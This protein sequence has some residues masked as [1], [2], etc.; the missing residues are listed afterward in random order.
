MSGIHATGSSS[1]A[2]GP[3]ALSKAH[4]KEPS[5]STADH[6][7]SLEQLKEKSPEMFNKMMETIGMQI[8]NQQGSHQKKLHE[9]VKQGEQG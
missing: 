9:I 7:Q 5:V 1:V 2:I 8:C 4:A 6:F 3:A